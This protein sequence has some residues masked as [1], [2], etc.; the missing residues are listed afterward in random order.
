MAGLST[1][2]GCELVRTAVQLVLKDDGFCIQ[3]EPARRARFLAE[4]YLEWCKKDE[5]ER[6]FQSFSDEL[7]MGLQGCFTSK[8]TVKV[9][10]KRIWESYF[11]YRSSSKFVQKWNDHLSP[12]GGPG[13]SSPIFYQFVTDV[14]ME[15]MIKIH[16]PVTTE[17]REC[18]A[19]LDYEEH[20]AIRYTAGYVLKALL[21][22][23]NH[24]SYPLKEELALCI[25]EL[26]EEGS[27]FS[28]A[29][30]EWLKAID[31]GGLVH[32][33]DMT[34]MLFTAMEQALRP[35]LVTMEKSAALDIKE[36]S[37]IIETDENVLFYWSILSVNWEEGAA[38]ALLCMLVER[39]I[40]LRGFSSASALMEKYKQQCKKNI[41]KSKG[42]RK[43]LQTE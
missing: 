14:I 38:E 23:I 1:P 41:Q 21:R 12:I 10:Q 22:K 18:S 26:K 34:Y 35:C 36:V 40:T 24:S 42:V 27:A 2:S 25:E 30:E 13:P 32:V 6:V 4:K 7:V 15:E 37:K 29:S 5:N 19:T 33:S 17:Q 8:P 20:N 11:K 3:S 39:W 43:R 28:H 9:R 31:R 16:F